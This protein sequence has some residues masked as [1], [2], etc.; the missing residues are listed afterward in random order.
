MV[1]EIKKTIQNKEKIL[2]TTLTKKMAEKL[3][4]HLKSIGIRSEYMHSD[5][6]TI[7]RIKILTSLR[8]NEFDVLV[9]INLLREGLDIPEVSLILV[10]DAD[11]EGFL[12]QR[13][14]CFKL[15]EEQLEM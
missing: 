12:D 13:P 14:L 9:G 2:V 7:E 3:T 8:N 11:K 4:D 6:D 5:I 1:K 15:R 10:L